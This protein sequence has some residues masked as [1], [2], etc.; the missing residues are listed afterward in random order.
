M[1]GC[2]KGYIVYLTIHLLAV[3]N[4]LPSHLFYR[5]KCNIKFIMVSEQQ[6]WAPST[7]ALIKSGNKPSFVVPFRIIIHPFRISFLKENTLAVILNAI[8]TSLVRL[9]DQETSIT[10]NYTS[11]RECQTN[12]T[13]FT[14]NEARK[15]TDSISCHSSK[16]HVPDRM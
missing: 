4:N 11:L 13:L 16:S 10:C 1:G 3:N 8:T 15:I 14:T 2:G 5:V 7:E 6:I 12:Y 9:L